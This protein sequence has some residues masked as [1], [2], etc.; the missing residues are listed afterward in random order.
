MT[1]YVN[2]KTG[3]DSNDGRSA[4]AALK[5]LSHA[6]EG[7]S[8]G[9]TILLVPGPYDQNLPQLVSA[10]RVAHINVGVVGGD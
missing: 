8:A 9:D 7:A 2:P 6:I 1:W 5:T 4:E 3:L 10:A